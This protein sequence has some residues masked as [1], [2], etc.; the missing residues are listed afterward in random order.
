MN[1]TLTEQLTSDWAA[2]EASGVT[3]LAFPDE[4]HGYSKRL[5]PE[6]Q[7]RPTLWVNF[8]LPLPEEDMSYRS[9]EIIIPEVMK[10]FVPRT[11]LGKKLLALR[12]QAIKAG[13]K[14][15]NAN[16]VL[17]EVKRRRGEIEDDEAD[18][19]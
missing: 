19:Y 14:L 17:E 5:F 12:T 16:E 15:L 4:W 9:T 2:R 3:F 18:V 10:M 11:P 7:R 6:S 13:M 8:V 1:V